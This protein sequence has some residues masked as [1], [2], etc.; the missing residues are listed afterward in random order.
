M[1]G[2]DIWNPGRISDRAVELAEEI[3]GQA[4]PFDAW[5]GEVENVDIMIASTGAPHHVIHPPHVE[6]AMRRRRGRPLFVIDIA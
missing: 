6:R 5:E 4:I 3:D 1:P 2:S